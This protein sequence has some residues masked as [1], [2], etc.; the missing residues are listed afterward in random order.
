[1]TN[2]IKKEIEK[3]RKMNRMVRNSMTEEERT[4]WEDEYKKQRRLMQ[5]AVR[6]AVQDHD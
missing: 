3:R 1:M 6:K 2:N 5:R 4:R